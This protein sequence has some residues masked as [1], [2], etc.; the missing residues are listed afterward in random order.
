VCMIRGAAK[1]VVRDETCG[2]RRVAAAR[3]A[4]IGIRGVGRRDGGRL[5]AGGDAGAKAPAS[6]G[7]GGDG[8]RAATDCYCL[9]VG[10]RAAHRRL[11][12]N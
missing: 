3:A 4:T 2:A 9:T 8:R 7:G 1:A 6:R 11:E 5:R 10:T 12:F